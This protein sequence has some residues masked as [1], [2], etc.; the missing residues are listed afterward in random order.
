MARLILTLIKLVGV[1][2]LVS[3]A[4]HSFDCVR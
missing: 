3:L 4:D 1:V 2:M